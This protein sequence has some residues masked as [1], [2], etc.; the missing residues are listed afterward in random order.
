M[1]IETPLNS[2]YSGIIQSVF[3]LQGDMLE[4]GTAL[5]RVN[6]IA[7]GTVDTVA[8]AAEALTA[9]QKLSDTEA[10]AL[11]Q[12][13]S[14]IAGLVLRIYKE[15]NETIA[16]G[17]SLLVMESMKMERP[18]NSIVSGVIERL[19][20]KQGDQIEAGQVLAIVRQ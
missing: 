6:T 3:I 18:V 14:P 13:L 20:V 7:H 11:T 4:T 1:N 19:A 17:E 15:P 8:R 16:A 10:E 9:E 5:Y 2:P 12:I